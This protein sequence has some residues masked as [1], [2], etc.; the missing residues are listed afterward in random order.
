MFGKCGLLAHARHVFVGPDAVSWRS[1][2]YRPGFQQYKQERLR[3]NCMQHHGRRQDS[4]PEIDLEIH[5][6]HLI[7]FAKIANPHLRR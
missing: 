7:V 6:T 1:Q 2:Q 3:V 4:K 5:S